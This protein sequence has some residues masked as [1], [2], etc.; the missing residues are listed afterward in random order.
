MCPQLKHWKLIALIS[1]L[2][3]PSCEDAP[4]PV[5]SNDSNLLGGPNAMEALNEMAS[6]QV[7][8]TKQ[9]CMERNFPGNPIPV[10]P[11][12]IDFF[13][14][15]AWNSESFGAVRQALDR[16]GVDLAGMSGRMDPNVRNQFAAFLAPMNVD[17]A[18]AGPPGL[19]T[20]Y[21][22][23]YLLPLL[24]AI[25]N[26]EPLES[27]AAQDV[28]ALTAAEAMIDWNWP[29]LEES[30]QPP[31]YPPMPDNPRLSDVVPV[32]QAIASPG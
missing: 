16:A 30:Q 32:I 11:P 24:W 3:V 21:R 8:F 6:V 19:G 15:A 2:A 9:N 4:P 28:Q 29:A 10:I 23:Y 27:L 20:A 5:E 25:E 14:T 31:Q 17:L 7:P 26:G 1:V 22:I 13:C 18:D 12:Q